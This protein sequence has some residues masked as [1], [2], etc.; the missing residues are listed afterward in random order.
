MNALRLALGALLIAGPASLAARDSGGPGGNGIPRSV[1]VEDAAQ[2]F[3]H[4]DRNGDG[5]ITLQEWLTADG[6]IDD[7]AG[8]RVFAKIDANGDSRVTKEEL[9]RWQYALF[10]C[11]DGNRDK[12]LSDTEAQANFA[13]C[14]VDVGGFPAP[15]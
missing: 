13:R 9:Y 15:S 6:E 5:L 14:T 7:A 11:I 1:V 3:A 4:N 12:W 10:D 8:K 2:Q